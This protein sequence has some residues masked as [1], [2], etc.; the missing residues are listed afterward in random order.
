MRLCR[1]GG[2]G[3]GCS[4]L[5]PHPLLLLLLLLR[6]SARFLARVLHG[7]GALHVLDVCVLLRR[8]LGGG[9]VSAL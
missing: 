4:W 5:P 7:N 2:G 9:L 6:L 3:C 1:Y 8:H